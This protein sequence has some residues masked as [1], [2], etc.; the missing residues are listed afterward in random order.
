MLHKK[1]AL[2]G[3]P[4]ILVASIPVFEPL[5]TQYWVRLVS[6]RWLGLQTVAPVSF[7]HLMLPQKQPPNTDLLL[8]S[9]LPVSALGE[10]R[11]QRFY[12]YS[13]FNPVQTQAFF[14]LYRT[15]D[16]VLL[17]APTGS[18]KTVAAELAV[19]RLLS[20]HPRAKAV[21]IAPIKALV[22]ERVKDWQRKFG[23]MSGLQKT[24]V[25][26]TGDTT[27][28][29]A[30]LRRADI[31]I[32]TPEKFD[33]VSRGWQHRQFVQDVGVV[34]LDE[35]HLLGEERGP[36]LEVI[37]SRLRY[38]SSVTG[39]A[40]RFVALST[41]LANAQDVGDWL[42]VPP[43]GLFNFRPSVRPVPMEAHIQ[44]FPGKHYCPRMASMNKPAFAAITTYAPDRPALVFVVSK[45]SSGGVVY[46]PACAP[47]KIIR[48]CYACRE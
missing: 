30:S 13:H 34:V 43:R 39:R 20:A 32:T 25:E 7:R 29:A 6:D 17:G 47:L 45:R 33:G 5:P 42:G 8:L 31:I 15:D 46:K 26:L 41:A 24:V 16:N 3:D 19:F 21:Y 28:D 27:P 12:G 37:V 40:V 14:T 36:V 4:I 18:G 48:S 10:A 35:V 11:F 9:P 22:A 44:G 38:M 2:S 23:A 1:Q